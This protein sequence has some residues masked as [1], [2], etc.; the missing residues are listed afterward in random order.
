MTPLE[1]LADVGLEIL[2]KRSENKKVSSND[3][4]LY[5]ELRTIVQVMYPDLKWASVCPTE[6]LKSEPAVE[7]DASGPPNVAPAP[8]PEKPKFYTP[9]KI[10]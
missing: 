9:P 6:V 8:E 5:K 10:L 7:F 4:E 1:K 3:L 2:R